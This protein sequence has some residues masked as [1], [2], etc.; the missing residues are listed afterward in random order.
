MWSVMYYKLYSLLASR[1]RLKSMEKPEYRG[2]K[3]VGVPTSALTDRVTTAPND[4]E[5]CSQGSW[6]APLGEGGLRMLLE[7]M[8][9]AHDG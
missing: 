9:D 8:R 4:Q 5:G 3:P 7:V 6:D 2:C 1:S